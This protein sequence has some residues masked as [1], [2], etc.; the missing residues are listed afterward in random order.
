LKFKESID[1]QLIWEKYVGLSIASMNYNDF[2][3]TYFYLAAEDC[4]NDKTYVLKYDLDGNLKWKINITQLSLDPSQDTIVQVKK[5]GNLLYIISFYFSIPGNNYYLHIVDAESG[6]YYGKYLLTEGSAFD[7]I[8]PD[9]D[10]NT[11]FVILSCDY[12]GNTY[13]KLTIFCFD[14]ESTTPVLLNSRVF[15]FE[16]VMNSYKCIYD[17]KMYITSDYPKNAALIVL[18]CEKLANPSYTN[19]ECIIKIIE[20][21][22]SNDVWNWLGPTVIDN[23]IISSYL[24]RDDSGYHRDYRF[25]CYDESK[26]YEKIWESPSDMTPEYGSSAPEAPLTYFNGKLIYPC[27]NYYVGCFDVNNGKLLWFTDNSLCEDPSNDSLNNNYAMGAVMNNKWYIQPVYSDSTIIIYD[28]T[29]GKKV[30]RIEN[31]PTGAG[32]RNPLWVVGNRIYVATWTDY[33]YC[34][35][36]SER[37]RTEYFI[38]PLFIVISFIFYGGYKIGK[39]KKNKSKEMEKNIKKGEEI[40][41]NKDN[42]ILSNELY[43]NKMDKD[44]IILKL[45]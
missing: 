29:T 28:I 8:A 13:R 6:Q 21:Q 36:I 30:G 3:G 43:E 33:F 7:G 34:F 25:A 9:T 17:G 37:Y 31:I 23:K 32:V 14:K 20:E 15:D 19:E 38:I 24:M 26:D 2:D 12:S 40:I 27:F 35:E 44:K 22:E 11:N 1:H 5:L 39:G 10:G 41:E 45:V 18:D 42:I 4:L 16:V